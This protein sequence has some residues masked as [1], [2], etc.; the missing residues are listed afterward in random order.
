MMSSKRARLAYELCADKKLY[1]LD[2]SHSGRHTTRMKTINLAQVV[3]DTLITDGYG[4]FFVE[5][6]RAE[7]Y[8]IM[9]HLLI[10]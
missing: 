9:A 5:N 3:G 1:R 7:L 8:E 2:E 10:L 4:V 6:Y